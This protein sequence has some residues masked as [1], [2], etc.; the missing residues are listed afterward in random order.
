MKYPFLTVDT[1]NVLRISNVVWA[2]ASE[3]LKFSKCHD[4]ARQAK[5]WQLRRVDGVRTD[6]VI[7][8]V[9]VRLAQNDS[10]QKIIILAAEKNNWKT[11]T[12]HN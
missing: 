2:R 12:C 4:Y 10:K 11:L 6:S 3:S 8:A 9:R 5:H 7:S 1:L